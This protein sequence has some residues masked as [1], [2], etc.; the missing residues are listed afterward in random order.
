MKRIYPFFLMTLI[1]LLTTTGCGLLDRAAQAIDTTKARAQVAEAAAAAETAVN[2]AAEAVQAAPQLIESGSAAIEAIQNGDVQ[3]PS[4]DVSAIQGQLQNVQPDANGIV[5][6]TLTDDQLNEAIA[7]GQTAVGSGDTAIILSDANITF[8]N[9]SAVLR[10]QLTQ[11]INGAL[12]I[13]LVPYLVN[14]S[15][16]FDVVSAD[17]GGLPIPAPVLNA[18][19]AMLNNSL[20]QAL[21]T[22]PGNVTLHSITLNEGS[23]TLSGSQS[24]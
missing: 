5:T 9:S 22:V 12:T 24:G 19:E 15:V 14:N 20:S 13:T 11:P 17:F 23:I 2:Q 6:I 16:V 21:A 10:G 18:A 1:L 4:I 7:N 8:T 3:L